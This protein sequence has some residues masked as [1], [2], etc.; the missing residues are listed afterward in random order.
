MRLGRGRTEH[1]AAVA[2]LARGALVIPTSRPILWSLGYVAILASA[3]A[4]WFWNRGV[5]RLG[6]ARAGPY[7]YLMPVYGSCFSVAL[8]GEPVRAVAA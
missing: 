4:F 8:L 6:P 5:M 7:L 1:D 2:A 3:L